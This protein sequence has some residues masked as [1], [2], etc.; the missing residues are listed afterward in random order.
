MT[1][2]ENVGMKKVL[3]GRKCGEEKVSGG[4]MEVEKC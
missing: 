1:E 4:R 2:D 3:G